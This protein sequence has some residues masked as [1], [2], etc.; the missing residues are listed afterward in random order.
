MPTISLQSID[1]SVI[2]VFVLPVL[3]L[4]ALL[5]IRRRQR[6]GR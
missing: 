3:W 1:W 5:V 2:A 4:G 6:R